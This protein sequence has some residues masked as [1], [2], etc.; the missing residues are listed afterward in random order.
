MVEQGPLTQI[1][2][3]YSIEGLADQ[4]KNL[5]NPLTYI[6]LYLNISPCFG[7]TLN[8]VLKTSVF[9]YITGFHD[10]LYFWRGQMKSKQFLNLNKQTLKFI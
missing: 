5:A 7:A 3:W 4:I 10:L 6:Y 9:W 1:N 8:L 2:T